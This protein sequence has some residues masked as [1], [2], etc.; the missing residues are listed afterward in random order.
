MAYIMTSLPASDSA[1]DDVIEGMSNEFEQS[2][3]P[4]AVRGLIG[5]ERTIWT[6]KTEEK[7]LRSPLWPSMIP[8]PRVS[9]PIA[10]NTNQ[11]MDGMMK[12]GKGIW[13]K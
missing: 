10:V 11:K 7:V 2:G 1:K 5:F 4:W 6:L 9:R 3:N 8:V 13:P 12:M